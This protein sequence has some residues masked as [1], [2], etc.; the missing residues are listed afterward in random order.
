MAKDGKKVELYEIL[1]AKRA[2]GKLAM[3]VDKTGPMY[4]AERALTPLVPGRTDIPRAAGARTIVID[5][6][7]DA[8]PAG[9]AQAY[10]QRSFPPAELPRTGDGD[11]VHAPPEPEEIPSEPRKRSMREVNFG[12]D[13]VF[14]L[15]VVVLALV[16]STYFLG[17]KRGQEERPTGLVGLADIE[18]ANP[19][20]YGLRN[21]SPA[22]RS[23]I[24]PPEQDFTLVLRTEPA[25]EDT[26]DRLEMELAEAMARGSREVGTDVPGFL[27]RSSRGNDARYVLAV[28]LGKTPNDPEL[29]RLLQVY[30]TMDGIA[31][32]REPRPYIG[33]QIAQVGDLGTPVD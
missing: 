3:P 27:F 25:E 11:V 6:A 23:S 9:G 20:L 24:H 30:N 16:G 17:Y 4:E 8:G 29:N 1:A 14:V 7:V 12:L 32:S 18:N 22:A 13:T 10:G 21:L 5:E 28:G 15:F 33:C 26:R 2:K 31:L 19:D